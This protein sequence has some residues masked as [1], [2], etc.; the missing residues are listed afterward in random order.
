MS[1]RATEDTSQ[2]SLGL[3][4]EYPYKFWIHE[5]CG[6]QNECNGQVRFEIQVRSVKDEKGCFCIIATDLNE[7]IE[8][9]F[10]REKTVIDEKRHA[11]SPKQPLKAEVNQSFST[12]IFWRRKGE[13]PKGMHIHFSRIK[14]QPFK[15]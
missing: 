10:G 3:L 7:G 14:A 15:T 8:V 12:Y 1:E 5:S 11:V 9:A 4:S 2:T 13:E 6:V